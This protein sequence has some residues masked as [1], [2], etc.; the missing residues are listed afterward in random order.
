[1]ILS[2]NSD[3]AGAPVHV[4]SVIS[5]LIQKVNFIAIFGE[6]GPIA[7]K[8]RKLGVTVE[9]VPEMKS[10]MNISLDFSAFCSISNCVKKYQ[11]DLI[12]AHSSKAGMLGRMISFQYKL[13]CIYTVHGWGWRGLGFIKG[14]IV[15][16][17]E[18][19]FSFIP[20]VSL[21]YVSKSVEKEARAKLLIPQ[22]RGLVIH[23]GV[24]D[25]FRGQE[26][27]FDSAPLRILMPA[28][29]S[30]A[31]DHITLIKAFE[32]IKFSSQL[33]LC[34]A[35]TESI[36]FIESAIQAAPKRSKDILFL[37]ARS[38]VPELLFNSDIFVLTSNFEALPISII[39]AMSA[40]KAII[41]S[42][43]GGVKE[44]IDNGLNGF[45]VE[46]GNV[47]NVVEALNSFA[48]ASFRKICGV[49]ARKKYLINFTLDI[50]AEKIFS[51]YSEVIFK[52]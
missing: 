14:A 47:A 20:R 9:I 52:R 22:K 16:L 3:E 15:F 44:L 12:H 25:L 42:D 24:A 5:S 30:P 43:V 28:R 27:S 46:K 10:T 29:V 37:G 19:I 23:N 35:G 7:E 1:M 36:Q 31:K 21:I 17:I 32:E 13:P 11:P 26:R 49:E 48:D 39:E 51:H 6:E 40:G 4:Y 41:A 2:T 8:V 33:L 50:M 18:K 45:C 34:G 38:D